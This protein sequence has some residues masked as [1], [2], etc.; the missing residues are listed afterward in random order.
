MERLETSHLHSENPSVVVN[1]DYR[2]VR[3]TPQI[4]AALGGLAYFKMTKH[5]KLISFA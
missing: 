4:K 2:L 5:C 3:K 1:T